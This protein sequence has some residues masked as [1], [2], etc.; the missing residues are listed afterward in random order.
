MAAMPLEGAAALGEEEL[1]ESRKRGLDADLPIAPSGPAAGAVLAAAAGAAAVPAVDATAAA[2]S[3]A[4]AL[5]VAA[6]VGGQLSERPAKRRRLD[7]AKVLCMRELFRAVVKDGDI[8]ES[9]RLVLQN[10][11]LLLAQ[12]KGNQWVNFQDSGGALQNLTPQQLRVLRPFLEDVSRDLKE[13]EVRLDS[14]DV[15]S[16]QEVIDCLRLVSV[17]WA[18]GI[19]PR[20][21]LTCCSPDE[22]LLLDQK[23]VEKLVCRL[24]SR[25]MLQSRVRELINHYYLQ[26]GVLQDAASSSS[27]RRSQGRRSGSRCARPLGCLA[28]VLLPCA[29]QCRRLVEFAFKTSTALVASLLV[30]LASVLVMLL[31]FSGRLLDCCGRC[32]RRGRA[33]GASVDAGQGPLVPALRFFVAAILHTQLHNA[34]RFIIT[35]MRLRVFV[36]LGT[37]NSFFGVILFPLIFIVEKVMKLNSGHHLLGCVCNDTDR[38]TV[39]SYV[40]LKVTA[41][42]LWL[43]EL[44]RFVPCAGPITAPLLKLLDA[45]FPFVAFVVDLTFS[46]GLAQ[47]LSM[48]VDL[49]DQQAQQKLVWMSMGIARMTRE[50]SSSLSMQAASAAGAA[51][52]GMGLSLQADGDMGQ[53]AAGSSSS[54]NQREAS[55]CQD[56]EVEVPAW[57]EDGAWT[58]FN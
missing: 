36:C 45:V 39:L 12:V 14:Q 58:L 48:L 46:W 30:A 54:V 8:T 10:T 11:A 27:S 34:L 18:D 31:S 51:D 17:P 49:A 56:M 7:Q 57:Q 4:A 22:E 50:G 42:L 2:S 15:H 16:K 47:G 44:V 6:A 55:G 3:A 23:W 29:R 53:S 5:A 33:P 24:P 43:L 52:S 41:A 35:I 21:L 13:H 19:T 26:R 25:Y 20:E 38:V 1:P 9:D 32:R 37:C 28:A 40:P